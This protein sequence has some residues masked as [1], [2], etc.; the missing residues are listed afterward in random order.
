M[1]TCPQPRT[2]ARY[3]RD[4]DPATSGPGFALTPHPDKLAEPLRWRRPRLVFVDSMSD[5]FHPGVPDDFI[6]DVVDVMER[7]D[8]HRFSC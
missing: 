3:Q 1:T 4:G 8:R 6:G 2:N 5:L 7:A